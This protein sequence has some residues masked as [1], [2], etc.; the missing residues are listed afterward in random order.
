MFPIGVANLLQHRINCRNCA[1]G[2]ELEGRFIGFGCLRRLH[3]ECSF[4]IGIHGIDAKR[5]RANDDRRHCKERRRHRDTHLGR[6]RTKVTDRDVDGRK[7]HNGQR[8]EHAS[9]RTR[10]DRRN[11]TEDCRENVTP[12]RDASVFAMFN[13]P[14]EHTN[15]ERHHRREETRRM[16][17]I[18]EGREEEGVALHSPIEERAAHHILND[19]RNRQDRGHRTNE[20]RH[21]TFGVAQRRVTQRK[22][23]HQNRREP[24]QHRCSLVRTQGVRQPRHRHRIGNT[25]ERCTRRICRRTLQQGLHRRVT[26]PFKGWRNHLPRLI[27]G[28]PLQERVR[29]QPLRC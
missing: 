6:H 17:R 9:T 28:I 23:G 16:V 24:R 2:G 4:R 11:R 19:T 1:V 7:A 15:R 27:R 8:E 22:Q 18:T 14:E 10:E 13:H 5:R 25:Y 29:I 12:R 26:Q 20:S 3:R 21:Q